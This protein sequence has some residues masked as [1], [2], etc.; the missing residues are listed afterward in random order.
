MQKVLMR[1]KDELETQLV[2]ARGTDF[3]TA[4]ADIASIGTVVRAT[5]LE[6]NERETFV[7]LGAWDSDPDKRI[8]SYLS[9]VAQALLNRKV[10]DQVEFEVHGARHRHRIETIET[11]KAPAAEV[12]GPLSEPQAA[13][14]ASRAR[15]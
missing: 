13:D 1:R 10:G 11:W 2:R 3:S 12:P 6:T 5:D 8:V 14:D 7:I 9:P 4:R 15:A